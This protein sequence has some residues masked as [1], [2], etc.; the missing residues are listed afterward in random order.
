M[1]SRDPESSRS[2]PRYVWCPLSRKRL[3]TQTWFQW[4]ANRKWPTEIRMVKWL[5][6]SRDQER[7][8]SWPR[9]IWGLL[10]RKRLEIRTWCQWSTYRKWLPGN[11]M[12]TWA[13]TSCDT[14]R[15]RSWPQYA[16]GSVSRKRLEIQTWFQWTPKEMVHWDSNGHLTNDVTWPRKVKVMNQ[17]YSGPI[18]SKTAG[19]AD[20]VTTGYQ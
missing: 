5:M 16:Y 18:I 13:M 11:Q 6:T 20:F 17:I 12:A 2:W 1:T 9:Y 19:G 10:Y 15:S 14:K 8:R 7:S 3:A 4:T